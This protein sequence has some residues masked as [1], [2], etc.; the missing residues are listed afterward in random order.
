MGLDEGKFTN[1]LCVALRHLTQCE[2]FY[3]PKQTCGH[4]LVMT[5]LALL[6]KFLF[7]HK[8]RNRSREEA[9]EEMLPLLSVWTKCGK[10]RGAGLAEPDRGCAN[11]SISCGSPPREPGNRT[12]AGKQ[13]CFKDAWWQFLF[14]FVTQSMW[15]PWILSSH[16]DQGIQSPVFS[17]LAPV[18]RQC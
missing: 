7:L 10:L 15:S 8:R 4:M 18:M 13:D 11:K 3:H 2:R 16:S 9:S 12:S 17:S 5:L 1:L 6:W 14:S